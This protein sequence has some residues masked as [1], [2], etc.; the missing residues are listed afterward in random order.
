M[1]IRRYKSG[2]E[3]ILYQIFNTSIH[4]NA[5]DYYSEEQLSAWAGG[6]I[7]E[8]QWMKRIQGIN[9]FVVEDKGEIIGY[10]DL[11]A[12]GYIDHFFVKGGHSG[13]GVGRY[14]MNYIIELAIHK[15]IKVLTANVSLSAQGFFSKFGFEIDV[16]ETVTIGGLEL[17]RAKM[18]LDVW[19]AI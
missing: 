13:Q 12:D 2:E 17:D 9:P 5:K 14:L 1:K 6:Y 8:E 18:S 4:H 10:A 7:S 3:M 16:H 15:K 11:Q 19:R